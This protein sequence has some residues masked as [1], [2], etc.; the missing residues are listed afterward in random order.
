MRRHPPKMC[1]FPAAAVD[2]RDI[3]T[4]SRARADDRGKNFLVVITASRIDYP[5]LIYKSWSATSSP[6]ELSP[7]YQTT[8]VGFFL[9]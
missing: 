3:I 7:F 5:P 8:G 9:P 4:A 1:G 6:Q 2:D